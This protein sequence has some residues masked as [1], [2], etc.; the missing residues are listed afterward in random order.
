MTSGLNGKISFSSLLVVTTGLLCAQLACSLRSLDYLQ[1]GAKQDAEVAEAPQ[2]DDSPPG[3]VTPDGANPTPGD[4]GVDA[5]NTVDT[6]AA[7]GGG[8]G[9]IDSGAGGV[10]GSGG[11]AKDGGGEGVGTGG[12][13]GSGGRTGSG[14]SGGLAS[15]GTGG[16]TVPTK[17]ALFVVASLSL[18]SGDNAI[19]S[20]LVERGFAVALVTDVGVASDPT[21]TQDVVVISRTVLSTNLGTALRTTARPVLVSEPYLLGEM[22]MVDGTSSSYGVSSKS[23]SVVVDSAAG[24]L[25]AGLSG[26]VVT[27]SSSQELNYGVPSAQAI[28]VASV[29][30]RSTQWAEF[31]YDTGAQMP[32]LA[33]PAR[34]VSFFFTET[35]PAY[36][37]SDGWRLFDAALAW[38]TE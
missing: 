32:G 22:G 20:R 3:G 23:S 15:G 2:Q 1:N 31:A 36:A 18:N 9:A 33:A 6:S 26:S 8:G 11:A 5:G 30:N 12:R 21:I 25:A 24:A 38:L 27:F 28:T 7:T 13:M 10:A 19:Q 4:A 37:N 29:P 17:S 35:S 16:A 34:R 14:G